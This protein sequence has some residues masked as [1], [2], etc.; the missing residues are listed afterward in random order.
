M[1]CEVKKTAQMETLRTVLSERL[2]SGIRTQFDEWTPKS[3]FSSSST[4]IHHF[5][6]QLHLADFYVS[7]TV[8]SW[9]QSL[10]P[11]D[12]SP[13][14]ESPLNVK[15]YVHVVFENRSEER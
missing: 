6:N 1:H 13:S 15:V 8:I 10:S 2:F 9:L 3:P 12:V 4:L 14:N 7:R 5:F 11:P